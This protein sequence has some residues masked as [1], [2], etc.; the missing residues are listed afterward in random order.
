VL[1][2]LYEVIER[3]AAMLAWYATYEPLGLAVED[4]EYRTL[5]RRARSENLEVT[6][7]LLTQDVD[8]PVVTA[9]VHR[10]GGEWPRFA[11]GVGAD[12]DPAAAARAALEEALQNWTELRGM[13]PGDAAEESGAIGH[14][15]DFPTGV[16]DLVTSEPTVAA[17]SVGPQTVPEG[18]GELGAVLDR[19]ADAGLDAYAARLTPRDIE[20]AG[21]EAVRVLVPSAQPLFTDDP[22]FGERARSVPTAL[23]F[24][25]RLD[26]AHHPFP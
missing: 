22:Y 5:V 3:D 7:L 9:A 20:R 15:A 10:E 16:E 18:R 2:G 12:L 21:F 13:G 4:G 19:L 14:Y 1:S 6:S 17:A 8:V 24:Q 25:P 11:T 23:G 26:R